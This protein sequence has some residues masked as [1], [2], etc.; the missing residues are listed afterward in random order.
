MN[1][2][3][4]VVGIL[5]VCIPYTV[6][7]E[8]KRNISIDEAMR[9]VNEV[10]AQ[11]Q[12]PSRFRLMKLG[13]LRVEDTFFHVFSTYLKDRQR[14]RVL[15]FAN[16]G[17]YLGFYETNEEPIELD[18]GEILFPGAPGTSDDEEG[19][20]DDGGGN[21]ITFTEKGPPEEVDLDEGTCRFASSP[22]RISATDSEY[23]FVLVV[24]ELVDAM[25]QRKY[26]RIRETFSES[27]KAK[28]SEEQT[29]EAF[30][31]VRK[32]VGDVK[33][34]DLPWLPSTNTAIF[35]VEFKR[36]LLGLKVLLDAEDKIDGLWVLP[37]KEAFPDLGSH[38]TELTLPCAGR[39]HVLWGGE[40]ANSSK[41][42]GDRS[43]Q[44]SREFVI[45][46]RY[47][48]THLDEGKRN[49]D[50]FAYGRPV[51]APAAGKVLTVVHDV[52]DH[53]PGRPDSYAPFGNT[54][55][56]RHASNEVSVIGHLMYESI[57]VKEGDLVEARQPV[58]R[59]GNSGNSTEPSI[60]YHM[61]NASVLQ[62]GF[63][64]RPM[65]TNILFWAK[66]RARVLES[67]IPQKGQY[68][69][70]KAFFLEKR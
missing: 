40:R 2:R 54:V 33:Y 5:A 68:I 4:L 16:S 31:N 20:S 30:T 12:F 55:V 3:F 42:Y 24:E 25:D 58:G 10:A 8:R 26:W 37:Y 62:R 1:S 6:S 17:H 49:T 29:K 36:G 35:P 60:Y 66:G 21:A 52:E 57:V 51:L 18:A 53:K 9:A 22:K 63:G 43:R 56:I 45:A 11:Q 32:K 34:V 13:P 61:Q 27:A 38:A 64:Y 19:D 65:F 41:Y 15:V 44:H 7:A 70:Q 69:E 14:W 59:C 28:L 47:G 67:L 46:D 48:Q 23:R 50:Y 39:W